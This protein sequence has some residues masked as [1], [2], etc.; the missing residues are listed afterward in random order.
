MAT[1]PLTSYL[2]RA[3]DWLGY[4]FDHHFIIFLILATALLL[5]HELRVWGPNMSYWDPLY[6]SSWLTVVIGLRLA[7]Q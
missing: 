3:T 5:I 2:R 7:R 1:Q 4:A 6:V